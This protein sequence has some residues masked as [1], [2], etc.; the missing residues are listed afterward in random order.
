MEG[1]AAQRGAV[2]EGVF[3]NACHAGG[4]CKG[5]QRGAI[6]KHAVLDGGHG[7]GQG[8]GFKR[9]TAVEGRVIKRRH[10]VGDSKTL[11]RGAVLE[12][13]VADLLQIVREGDGGHIGAFRERVASDRRHGVGQ[14][15]CLNTGAAVEKIRGNGC[16]ALGER[17]VNQ[18]VAV[19]ERSVIALYR[20]VRGDVDG[21]QRG[22][23]SERLAA[24]VGQRFGQGDGHELFA[25]SKGI[26]A[27]RLHVGAHNQVLQILAAIEGVAAYLRNGIGQGNTVKPIAV[28]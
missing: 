28:I 19:G 15:D 6:L 11:Q 12:H 24:Q 27:D 26:A 25:M 5:L 1:E 16:S 10:A 23:A 13:V 8:D 18:A 21:G 17:H 3:F 9:R 14:G 22:A 4:R 7:V 20:Q 2:F